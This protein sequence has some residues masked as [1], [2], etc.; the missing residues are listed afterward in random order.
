MQLQFI[1]IHIFRETP[2]VT[3]SDTGV[4]ESNGTDDV[5]HHGAAISLPENK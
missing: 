5:G 2:S 3:F 1:P 4:P